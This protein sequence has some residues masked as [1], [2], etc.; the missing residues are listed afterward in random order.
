MSTVQFDDL[1]DRL[2]KSLTDFNGE[3]SDERTRLSTRLE[4]A[5]ERLQD[6]F[7]SAESFED[8]TATAENLWTVIDEAEDVL[9]GFD[10]ESF[11]NTVDVGKLPDVIE[12]E[13]V[14]DAVESGD[15]T[16]AIDAKELVKAIN[17]RE[18]WSSE[19]MQAMWKEG[20][21]LA[22]AIGV[23]SGNDSNDNGDNGDNAG[24][25]VMGGDTTDIASEATEGK[26]QS[27]LEENAENFRDQIETARERLKGQI[28]ESELGSG[29]GSDRGDRSSSPENR[30]DMQVTFSYSTMPD[31]RPDIDA[32]SHYSTMPKRE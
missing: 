25:G 24:L 12:F 7:S 4:T 5:L 20:K 22:D 28:A 26:L 15:P 8:V 10:A 13:D 29:E 19:E 2:E 16:A 6:A 21:E 27:E 1:S 17:F 31:D 23:L 11:G 30:P 3:S 18:F 9:A 14:P 32:T